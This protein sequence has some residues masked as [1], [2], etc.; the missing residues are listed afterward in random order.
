MK[1]LL[2][3]ETDGISEIKKECDLLGWHPVF[4]RT[5]QYASWLPQERTEDEFDIRSTADLSYFDI[6]K[7]ALDEQVAGI[8]PIS[9]LEPEGVRD[10]LVR[11]Y[12]V[13]HQIPI[14]MVANSPATMESTFDKWLTKSILGYFNIPVTPDRP[15]NRIEDLGDIV[16]EFGFP[17]IVK[18]RKSY[19]GMGVRIIN[20]EEEL[21]RYI[22]KNSKKELFAEPFLSGSEISME[23]IVWNDKIFFQPL[24]YKGETRL[25]I[26]EHP[27]YRPRIS[28]YQ[29][30]SAL[31]RKMIT[32]VSKAVEHLQL[33]GAAEFEFLIVDGEPLIMEIN[34]R[35]SGVTR[36]C[37]AAGGANVYRELT[38]LCTQD[39]LR[40]DLAIH[41]NNYAIQFP[42]NINP[43]GDLL[44]EM[45]Q[46]PHISYIKPVTWMPILP[47]RSNVIMSY[48]TPDG[49]LKGIRAL[50]HLTDPR[51][52]NEA[53]QSF[54]FF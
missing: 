46:D 30:G 19:T 26:I 31:E 6:I 14:R 10:S 51:Y 36:L 2:V 5:N 34:P 41:P 1:K 25:N 45:Q 21:V 33:N 49:L 40:K 23:V 7:L 11:D 29:S 39:T 44:K 32:I 54:D 12:I 43:E 50:E 53:L 52:I 15:I 47:I 9:L 22:T 35:I 17:L 27:A 18:E 4:I 13:N 37:N 20:A 38:Y 24:V 16:K 28:P 48:D 3:I 42:L 8:L